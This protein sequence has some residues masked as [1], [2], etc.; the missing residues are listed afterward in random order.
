MLYSPEMVRETI[1]KYI[2]KIDEKW[3]LEKEKEFK[4]HPQYDKAEEVI[5]IPVKDYIEIVV[6]VDDDGFP[7][8]SVIEDNSYDEKINLQQYCALYLPIDELTFFGAFPIDQ[9]TTKDKISPSKNI[10]ECA[11]ELI[12]ELSSVLKADSSNLETYKYISVVL[13]TI[14]S[15]LNLLKSKNSGNP[16]Y[17]SILDDFLYRCTSI[18]HR[19][20]SRELTIFNLT[21]DHV[22]KLEFSLN[23]DQL[24]A[25]LFI[26]QRAGFFNYTDNTS[27]LKFALHHF[28]YKDDKG[29]MVSPSSLKNLQKK[30][31][32]VA[33]SQTPKS[34][35]EISHKGLNMVETTLKEILKKLR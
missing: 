19:R 24:L 7:T 35:Q 15:E 17:I 1:A 5:I 23:Q 18:I 10:D 8:K 20:Y 6:E 16:V 11:R 31:S 4:A 30:F 25:L 34:K 21:S 33:A 9:H 12:I 26:L 3:F 28:L 2:Y 13:N 14:E 22:G 32:D 27:L 29:E